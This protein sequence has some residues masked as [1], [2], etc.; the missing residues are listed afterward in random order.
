MVSAIVDRASRN[1]RS[2]GNE[3]VHLLTYGLLHD[4]DEA[5]KERVVENSHS[6]SQMFTEPEVTE[7]VSHVGAQP[8][9][10]GHRQSR[11]EKVG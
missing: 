5:R 7:I 6:Q 9:S 3:I 4:P 11:K 1:H 10:T 2:Q 8:R